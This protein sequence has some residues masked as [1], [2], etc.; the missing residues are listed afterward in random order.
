MM[1]AVIYMG[2]S[3]M[4]ADK[5]RNILEHEGLLVKVKRIGRNDNMVYE[6]LVP[7]E[8]VEDA[9]EVLSEVVY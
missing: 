4:D 7:K 8:E 5:I 3:K 1:W 6:I 9:H 2:H